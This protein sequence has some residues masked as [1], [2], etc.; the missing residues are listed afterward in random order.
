MSIREDMVENGVAFWKHDRVKDTPFNE[1]I[2]FLRQKGLTQEEIDE[3]KRRSI[4]SEN[5]A[6]DPATY[7]RSQANYNPGSPYNSANNNS[8]NNGNYGAGNNMPPMPYPPIQYVAPPPRSVGFL[9][10]LYNILAPIVTVGAL[11]AGGMYLYQRLYGPPASYYQGT[12]AGLFSPFQN[13]P[14][15][16][17]AG[18]PL[19]PHGSVA[20]TT[21]GQTPG[22]ALANDHINTPNNNNTAY[23]G[24]N[25]TSANKGSMLNEAPWTTSKSNAPEITNL[26]AEMKTMTENFE[27]QSKQL[28][29]AIS[30][31]NE[32]VQTQTAQSANNTSMGL[33]LANH[34]ANQSAQERDIKKELSQI[35]VI[36]ATGLTPQGNENKSKGGSGASDG[37]G[38]HAFADIL[39]AAEEEDARKKAQEE[40][41]RQEKELDE[42]KEEDMTEE[43]KELKKARD[44]AKR[45]K[46]VSDEV[47]RMKTNIDTAMKNML[48]NNDTATKKSAHGMLSMILKNLKEQPDVPRYRRV[49]K[50]N[51]NFKKMV[52]PLIGHDEFLVSMG[53]TSRG[54]YFE[55]SL[56]PKSH[57]KNEDEMEDAKS[58]AQKILEHAV[59]CVASLKEV[60]PAQTGSST[61]NSGQPQT[62][63]NQQQLQKQPKEFVEKPLPSV[64]SQQTP[65][66]SLVA[67]QSAVH[68]TL[69]NTNGAQQ[70]ILPGPTS[71]SSQQQGAGSGWPPNGTAMAA[72]KPPPNVWDT[73]AKIEKAQAIAPGTQ[74]STTP[75][76]GI[77]PNQTA[78]MPQGQEQAGNANPNYPLSFNEIM[79][80]TQEGKTPP[81]IQQIP[82]TLSADQASASTG[83]AP[84]KPWENTKQG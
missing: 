80:M 34:A 79:K 51:P 17:Q 43:E 52:V 35:K 78:A 25:A 59:D 45:A 15:A 30:T 12:G 73:N 32:I 21:P 19:T 47:S 67:P 14:M 56:I 46:R 68:S 11:G 5:P 24:I 57:E 13:N 8:N 39:K 31:L 40:K 81:G 50:D 70:N 29:D 16:T 58:I 72:V 74:N 64:N 26:R 37:G 9:E 1:R 28:R 44:K 71:S 2:S 4:E 27:N 84:S 48:K 6:I 54:N 10:R 60:K 62:V 83:T 3:V 38:S 7:Q 61:P 75:V 53:F 36:L 23:N 69:P 76:N 49:K 63:I 20:P 82:N 41:E 66:N 33:L 18:T 22:N 42:K 55:F 65:I 77:A